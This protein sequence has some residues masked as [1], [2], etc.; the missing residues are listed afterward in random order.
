MLTQESTRS[1]PRP[2]TNRSQ[3]PANLVQS[4]P[5]VSSY[6]WSMYIRIESALFSSQRMDGPMYLSRASLS[7]PA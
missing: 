3:N 1:L 7:R 6:I 5:L 2:C 4:L